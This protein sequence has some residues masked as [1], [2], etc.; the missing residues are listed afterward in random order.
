MLVIVSGCFHPQVPLP[1]D[2][3]VLPFRPLPGLHRPSDV[4]RATLRFCADQLAPVFTAL[5]NKLLEQCHVPKFNIH[6][7]RL[8]DL[9]FPEVRKSIDLNE[10]K[11][12]A[13][14]ICVV[15]S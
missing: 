8:I 2:P 11:H 7:V 1:P 13:S 9:H 5:F 3:P 15:C 4:S 6:A 10:N 14:C 12:D